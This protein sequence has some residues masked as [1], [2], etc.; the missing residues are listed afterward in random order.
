MIPGFFDLYW[1]GTT[2][3]C[4]ASPV[5]TGINQNRLLYLTAAPREECGSSPR[6]WV[7]A[8][9]LVPGIICSK[10]P[11]TNRVWQTKFDKHSLTNIVWQTEFDK[12]SLT[13]RVWRTE[14]DKPSLT[15]RV[16]QTEFDKPSSTNRVWQTE[17]DKQSLTNLVWQTEFDKQSLT[18]SVWQPVLIN[19]FD[20]V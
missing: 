9:S 10:I 14:F 19:S 4:C 13:N 1:S 17:F 6:T 15:N 3:F 20:S 7:L 18:N 11:L 8:K 12:P 5:Y 2:V 16:W